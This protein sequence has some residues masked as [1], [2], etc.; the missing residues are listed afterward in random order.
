MNENK[1]SESPKPG[2]KTDE[3]KLSSK[4]L[5]PINGTNGK[6]DNWNLGPH[7]IIHA[8]DMLDEDEE[9]SG[10][11]KKELWRMSRSIQSSGEMLASLSM[12]DRLQNWIAIFK[13]WYYKNVSFQ[14]ES[15]LHIAFLIP[16][17]F[18]GIMLLYIRDGVTFPTK[19]DAVV[20]LGITF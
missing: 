11:A 20:M 15:W 10:R 17:S 6:S 5:P 7:I 19:T 3:P 8:S 2:A 13:D 4:P 16:F 12:W 9:F 18:A 1:D 14:V